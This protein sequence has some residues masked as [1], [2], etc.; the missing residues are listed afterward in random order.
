MPEE[1]ADPPATGTT[2]SA[3]EL[4]KA[5]EVLEQVNA[6]RALVGQPPLAWDDGVAETA[7][8]HSM[9]MQARDY[10]DHYTPEGLAPWDRLD[11]R[12]V[13][14]R[15][16]GENIYWASWSASA[17][18]AMDGWM[19]STGHRENIQRAGWTHTGI[20]VR[21]QGS[22]GSWWTQVFISR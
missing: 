1:P 21:D 6:E 9:D 19:N 20:G 8:Q 22:G 17:D 11:L 3:G 10:F 2:M 5:L 12:D 14:Y 4:A 7:Y 16:A 13:P 18:D 15:S